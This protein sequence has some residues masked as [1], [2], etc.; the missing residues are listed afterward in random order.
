MV[1]FIYLLYKNLFLLK[2]ATD[3]NYTIICRL[4]IYKGN[5]NINHNQ[6]IFLMKNKYQ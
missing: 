6:S 4:L 2:P 5:I 1:I 3:F